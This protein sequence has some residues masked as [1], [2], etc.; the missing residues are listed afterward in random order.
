MLRAV[1]NGI[2]HLKLIKADVTSLA[3]KTIGNLFVLFMRYLYG[4]G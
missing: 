3:W 2:Q 1:K 4:F